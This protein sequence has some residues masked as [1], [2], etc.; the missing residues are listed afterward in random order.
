MLEEILNATMVSKP[1]TPE[2]KT[3][4]SM[5]QKIPHCFE[6]EAIRA[7]LPLQAKYKVANTTPPI[8]SDGDGRTALKEATLENGS[9]V[10]VSEYIAECERII[11]GA[12]LSHTLHAYGT[13]IEGDWDEVFAC[14][15]ACHEAVHEMGAPRI[16]TTLKVGTRTDRNQSMQDKVDSVNEKLD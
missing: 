16:T 7:R 5:L 10:S 12:G 13:N 14:V 9:I 4:L 11:Q 3:L 1:L 8:Q 15:K 6:D 2:Q